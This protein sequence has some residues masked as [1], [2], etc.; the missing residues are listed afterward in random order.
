MLDPATCRA[1]ESTWFQREL[2]V[3]NQLLKV[4]NTPIPEFLS[5]TVLDKSGLLSSELPTQRLLAPLVITGSRGRLA[6]FLTHSRPK[7]S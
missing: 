5:T 1:Q 2:L 3:S 7:A 6:T 4:K